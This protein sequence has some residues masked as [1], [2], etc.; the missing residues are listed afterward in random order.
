[1]SNAI[2]VAMYAQLSGMIIP[3]R[4]WWPFDGAMGLGRPN[5]TK[6]A[7]ARSNAT[8]GPLQREWEKGERKV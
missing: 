4:H 7:V 8:Y 5:A 6:A 1:M 2:S 3:N